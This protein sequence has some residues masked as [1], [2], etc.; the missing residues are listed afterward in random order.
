MKQICILLPVILLLLGPITSYSQTKD[1]IKLD[2]GSTLSNAPWNNM[3]SPSIGKIDDLQNSFGIL[4]GVSVA[5]VDSFNAI[6]TDGT[7]SP[8]ASLGYPVSAT[9]DSFF[10]N[11]GLFNGQI[12]T[13]GALLFANLDTSKNYEFRIFASRTASDNRQAM[14]EFKGLETDTIYLDAASNVDKIAFTS[15]KPDAQGKILLTASP[16]P[17]NTNASKFYYIGL[18]ELIYEGLGL[19]VGV[20]TILVDF[21]DNLSPL[22]WNNVSDPILGSIEGLMNAKGHQTPFGIGVTDAFNNINRD[23]TLLPDSS[24]GMPPSATGDSFFGNVATFGGQQQP[25]GAIAFYNLDKSL[26]YNF[27][28]FGSRAANDN[29]ETKF[30]AKGAGVDSSFIN[31]ASNTLNLARLS[32]SPDTSGTIQILVSPGPNNS[33]ASKFFYMGAIRMTYDEQPEPPEPPVVSK[34]DSILVDFGDNLSG[35]PWI[36]VIDPVF[37]VAENLT[38]KTG[39]ETNYR[40]AITD[41][42]N[43]INRAG[44]VNP[45]PGIGFPATVSGDSFFGNIA[46]FGGQTQPTGAIT[47]S[48]LNPSINYEFTF[49]ASRDAADNREAIYVLEGIGLDT[50]Y[51]NASSNVDKVA[52]ASMKSNKFGEIVISVAP[53]PNNNNSSAFYYIGGMIVSYED[54]PLPSVFDTVSI[55]F[56]TNLSPSPWNNLDDARRGDISDM[57][58]GRSINS[59]YG[60][61]ITD[62]FN[63]VNTNGTIN[64]KA[65]LGLPPTASGDSFYGNVAEFSGGIEPTGAI[66]LYN[67]DP[68]Q[69]YELIIFASRSASDNRETKY[70]LVGSDST[71]LF[72]NASSNVDKVVSASITP[73]EKGIITVK[74]SPG[75]NNNNASSF[76]YL[77]SLQMIFKGSVEGEEELSLLEPNGGEIWEQG[78]EVLIKWRSR[79][80]QEVSLE[81]SI[82]LG[83]NWQ[84]IALTNGV[85]GQYNW[86]V[87][88]TPSDMALVRIKGGS[89]ED[90]SNAPFSIVEDDNTCRIVVLGSSTAEGS[91]AS[92]R[93]S[94][95]VNRYAAFLSRDS[96]YEVINLGR[97]GYNTYHILPTGT[98]SPGIG[99]AIDLQRNVTKALSYGPSTIIVNMPSNDA[100]SN[101]S[102]NQQMR[103]FEL[104]AQAAQN[105]GVEIYIC[106]TQPR[107]FT[108]AALTQIQIDVRDSIFR[109]FGD[110]AIDFWSGVADPTG[111]IIPQYDSG[112][113][114][115]L[116]NSGH[117]ILYEKIIASGLQNGGCNLV[118]VEDEAFSQN[119]F[120]VFPNPNSGSFKIMLEETTA[121]DRIS[122]FDALGRKVYEK[123]NIQVVGGVHEVEGLVLPN[124]VYYCMITASKQGRA[125]QKVLPILIER[126]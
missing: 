40:L 118:G 15:M 73:N 10:G 3:N 123:G 59:G 11:V 106:T 32:M 104:V 63:G 54:Q 60:V 4:T 76:F 50:T 16:G 52:R 12:Q 68:K 92:P 77:G 102:L 107:N 97:G 61:R 41:A 46:D 109:R 35:A 43:N 57:V 58:T 93:D 95:W 84:N 22:P 34:V 78:R 17:E 19:P 125:V 48:N 65:D 7:K 33:N 80:I 105:A 55:D 71:T 114:V 13:T 82:D 29:R 103:N 23:G 70:E 8:N 121:I 69:K 85:S 42:F 38:T 74:A 94:A 87:P 115:H 79:N 2:F 120:I 83:N 5:V 30:E 31:T 112:D 110:H 56:G 100:A 116:N 21:G 89:L 101:Y 1:T 14:Y 28:I 39:K 49:F 108:N 45:S 99:V 96:R 67:L 26:V 18:V 124:G 91:G 90:V 24:V 51:L 27:E 75:P 88:N 25:T 66:E 6:N 64:P 111:R 37:G 81:Y 20:D 117:R 113:G 53:G 44:T 98:E 72:L 122:I 9:G 126:Q 36:D 47:L 62:V 119:N 86:K